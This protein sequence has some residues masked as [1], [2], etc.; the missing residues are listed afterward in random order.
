[1]PLPLLQ[2][3]DRPVL[4]RFI[5]IA[6]VLLN[7]LPGLAVFAAS[8][9]AN[10]ST[11]NVPI[12]D[13]VYRDIDRLVGL[14]LAK[15][16]LYGQ[17]PWSRGEIARLI[18][19]ARDKFNEHPLSPEIGQLLGRL[20]VRFREE[21]NQERVSIHPLSFVQAGYTFLDGEPRPIPI[22]GLGLVNAKIEPLTAYKEGRHFP[23]GHQIAVETEHFLT[24]SRYF[25]FYLRPRF[26]FDV[27]D[28]G[29]A[30]LEP[31]V[32]QVYAK[33]GAPHF[34]LEAGRD[35]LEWGQGEFGG[36]L[37]SNNARPLDMVK[38]S[39]PSP[40]ILP[41]IFKYIGLIR[42]SLFVANLGPEREFPYSFLTGL[43]L[44]FKPVSYFEFGFS[45]LVM[46]GGDGAPD[47]SV[48]RALSEFFGYRG[49]TKNAP[50]FANR[51]T[52]FDIRFYFPFLRNSQLYLDVQ[53]EDTYQDISYIF[54]ELANYQVGF[55]IP[56][57][58]A[59]GTTSLRLEY[60]H[61]SPYFYRHGT[62]IT[63]MA[64]NELLL[65]DEL[66]PQA[67]GAYVDVVHDLSPDLQL[68][69]RFRYERRD[70]D[71]LQE[72]LD[73]DGNNRRVVVVTPEPAEQRIGFG[74]QGRYFINPKIWLTLD[75]GYERIL[76]FNFVKG[77]D[78]NGVVGSA[79]V[80]FFLF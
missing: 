58:D 42:Y 31:F 18:R 9:K 60:R 30:D 63:G 3:Y 12:D 68:T 16:V 19:R 35:S 22:N 72:L 59:S 7:L 70:G 21:L 27:T 75:L 36:I 5:L 64:L 17:R 65:G 39:N 55:F 53:F 34:E 44:S 79:N 74:V 50:N 15:D 10:F 73:P 61:G 57:L 69:G 41:W 51:E 25:S 67:D 37:L 77:D 29:N 2:D 26:D 20:E 62:F 52:G 11:P 13:P 54:K 28:D 66:G 48:K 40:S 80:R 33:F 1:M 32:Q 4:K 38:I 6:V 76:S 56:C 23:D 14:G 71:V 47:L 45:Q 8:A 46:M 78:R 43:K 24:A 49:N